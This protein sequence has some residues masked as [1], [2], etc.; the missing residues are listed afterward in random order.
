MIA[1]RCG[2]GQ[3]AEGS[4]MVVKGLASAR[5]R[6]QAARWL[7]EMLRANGRSLARSPE[8]AAPTGADAAEIDGLFVNRHGHGYGIWEV[9][10]LGPSTP[11][12]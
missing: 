12:F 8:R 2:R 6:R 3:V 4:Q 1:Q 10:R 9:L 5:R 7:G 11:V